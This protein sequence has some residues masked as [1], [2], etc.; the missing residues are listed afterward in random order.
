MMAEG[1]IRFC[2]P[3]LYVEQQKE[4]ISINMGC[5]KWKRY[6]KCAINFRLCI[7]FVCK[8]TKSL[9]EKLSLRRALVANGILTVS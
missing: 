1:W 8:I 4:N 6:L 9:H 2:T 3:K 7:P 5:R